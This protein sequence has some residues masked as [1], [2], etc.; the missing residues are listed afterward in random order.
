M[1]AAKRL[2]S[3]LLAFLLLTAVA[4]TNPEPGDAGT[5]ESPSTDAPE[6]G[7]TASAE[8]TSG[9]APQ[10]SASEQES[11]ATPER[12]TSASAEDWKT[13]SQSP[14]LSEEELALPTPALIDA[15][16]TEENAY[17]FHY[18]YGFN[19]AVSSAGWILDQ[20][21]LD[22]W[23]RAT[24]HSYYTWRSFN[25]FQELETRPDA[26]ACLLE[27]YKTS[28]TDDGFGVFY[29]SNGEYFMSQC[30]EVVLA[31]NFYFR[32]LTEAERDT[33]YETVVRLHGEKPT[34]VW[35]LNRYDQSYRF[36]P[37]Y[38]SFHDLP[39]FLVQVTPGAEIYPVY[40]HA[41]V[42]GVWTPGN[43]AL[44]SDI[45]HQFI[46]ALPY[47][48]A[49]T[50]DGR[51]IWQRVTDPA[52]ET[53]PL[54]RLTFIEGGIALFIPLDEAAALPSYTITLTDFGIPTLLPYEAAS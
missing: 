38:V 1:K 34:S 31:Q 26:A 9:D 49:T 24:Y 19:S 53:S 47:R 39:L 22:Y 46:D 20:H 50:D 13:V 17:V 40:T 43:E 12:D 51:Q 18:F 29:R 41:A 23:N 35:E 10:D 2:L 15:I 11:E 21:Q 14:T 45:Y 25:G 36:Y 32:Q 37:H 3:L 28:D 5:T 6:D 52:V 54:Y 30:L 16:F 48:I 8:T 4:C 27:K 33:L 44:D 7:T 42:S